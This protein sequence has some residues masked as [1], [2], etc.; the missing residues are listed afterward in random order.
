MEAWWTYCSRAKQAKWNK[1][2]EWMHVMAMQAIEEANNIGPLSVP[3]PGL[4]AAR[5]SWWWRESQHE[6]A[7]FKIYHKFNSEKNENIYALC[8]ELV[9]GYG[10]CVWQEEMWKKEQRGARWK[11][12]ER[13]RRIQTAG[14]NKEP[15]WIAFNSLRDEQKRRRKRWTDRYFTQRD[16]IV[17]QFDQSQRFC[18][19]CGLLRSLHRGSGHS[20]RQ[21]PIN[22]WFFIDYSLAVI[23][24]ISSVTW[25]FIPLPHNFVHIHSDILWC[26]YR[27]IA[28][29]AYPNNKQ[30][31]S[32]SA[33]LERIN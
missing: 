21:E 30:T 6:S 25:Y 29:S 19:W 31:R 4:L 3:F 32:N 15:E 7:H 22:L 10:R 13:K 1:V 5:Y 24:A 2:N 8:P 27:A 9:W 28:P 18:N 14:R 20:A 17:M 23:L 12:D 11:K 16:S 33:N 26:V